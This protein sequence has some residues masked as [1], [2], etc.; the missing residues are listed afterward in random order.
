MAVSGN[1]GRGALLVSLVLAVGS[2]LVILFVIKPKI[3]DRGDPVTPVFGGLYVRARE[4]LTGGPIE[5][6]KTSMLDAY[7]GA[8]LIWVLLPVLVTVGAFIVYRIRTGKGQSVYWPLTISMVLLALIVM[9]GRSYA[10]PAL[11]AM[12]AMAVASFQVRKAE[13]PA[14][15]A[16]R[17]AGGG[18]DVIE[19]EAEEADSDDEY[20]DEYED[21]DGV[22]E[23]GDEDVTD[24]DVEAEDDV[25]EVE[26]VGADDEAEEDPLTA[27]EEEIAQEAA[28]SEESSGRKSR[29]GK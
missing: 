4:V 16:E 15:M 11:P 5:T 19:A 24:E 21:E 17:V 3:D 23:D 25:I 20:D 10:A 1:P 14:R 18:D 2:G 12:V 26:V 6:T 28:A 27:L 8:L 13:M 29:R 22:Y 7:G 9:T